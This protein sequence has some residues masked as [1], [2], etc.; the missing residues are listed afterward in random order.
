[1][2]DADIHKIIVRGIVDG[3]RL[4][5]LDDAPPLIRWGESQ[6]TTPLD[7]RTKHFNLVMSLRDSHRLGK[8]MYAGS[9]LSS[10]RT[11]KRI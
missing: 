8:H 4:R 9:S 5:G 6:K 7:M 11:I 2:G 1:M 3:Q 10:N